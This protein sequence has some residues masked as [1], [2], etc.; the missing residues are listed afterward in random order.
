VAVASVKIATRDFGEM[1]VKPEELMVFPDGLIGFEHVKRYALLESPECEPF[2]WLQAVDNPD[3]AFVIIDPL[4]FLDDYEVQVDTGDV[5]SLGFD[6][7]CNAA[8]VALMS[9]PVDIENATMNLRAPLVINPNTCR[10]RQVVLS[11]DQH[12][13]KYPLFPEKDPLSQ[14]ENGKTL[15]ESVIQANK[16]ASRTEGESV[17]NLI[18]ILKDL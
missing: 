5:E 10:G 1:E 6:D 4:A 12:E 8:V 16:A 14:E 3:V 13:T 15:E 7:A 17:R 9:I 11:D 18:R 2:V